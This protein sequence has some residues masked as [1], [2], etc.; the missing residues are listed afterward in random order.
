VKFLANTGKIWRLGQ[1]LSE[2]AFLSFGDIAALEADRYEGTTPSSF[3]AMF[4][5]LILRGDFDTQPL[6][7]MPYVD[8]MTID[9]SLLYMQI[10]LISAPFDMDETAPGRPP[11]F[12]GY[13]C[14]NGE[15][16]V[17]RLALMHQWF[18][19]GP[20]RVTAK[21]LE[22]FRDELLCQSFETYPDVVQGFLNDTLIAK[23]K[24]K[25]WY[26]LR[27]VTIPWNSASND[28]RKIQNLPKIIPVLPDGEPQKPKLGRPPKSAWIFIRQRSREL[29]RE[30]LSQLNKVIAARV[31]AEAAND[32]D[33][34]E[35]PA[36]TTVIKRMGEFFNGV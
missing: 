34:N 7:P 17:A 20:E 25:E 13:G 15:D 9:Q 30:D 8:L 27:G 3:M 1:P 26:R 18:E 22:E 32:F 28:N 16:V 14:A 6:G 5:H 33:P 36:E 2:D 21:Q 29:K 35:L 31:L 4:A 11:K 19:D 24:M 23:E 10:P 12:L